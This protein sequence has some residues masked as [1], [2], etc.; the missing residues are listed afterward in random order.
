MK[1][2]LLLDL[3]T[4]GIFVTIIIVLALVFWRFRRNQPRTLESVLESI[5]Y[6]QLKQL[7]IPKLDEG[8][9]QIDYLVLHFLEYVD[10][11]NQNPFLC[12]LH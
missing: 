8:E 12:L 6:K 2:L 5:A 4:I 9:I 7:V 11:A 1:D 10:L 3:P